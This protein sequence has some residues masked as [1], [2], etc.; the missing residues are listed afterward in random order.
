MPDI[1]H[2][3]DSPAG[4]RELI[5]STDPDDVHS[6]DYRLVNGRAGEALTIR[7]ANPANFHQAISDTGT[8]PRQDIWAKLFLPDGPPPFGVVIVVPGSL[9]LGPHHLTHAAAITDLGLAACGLDPFGPRS[10][11]STIA[12]QVQY[13]FAASAWDVLATAEALASRPDIDATRIGAQGHSRGGAAVLSAASVR[14]A[15][16]AGAPKLAGVYGAYPWCGHQFLDPD[17][18]G[19]RVRAIIGDQD[20]WCSPAQVQAHM[21]AIGVAGGDATVRIVPGAHHSF[22]RP[23]PL[24]LLGDAAVS[25][26]APT[27]YI[28]DDGAFI[29]PT[30]DQPDPSLVDLDG[31]RYALKAGYGTRG[32]HIGGT[33]ESAALFV[34]DMTD[35]W[36][37][38]LSPTPK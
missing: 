5:D 27:V 35:F 29:L 1:E 26:G 25:P 23:T 30:S 3:L 17:V 2:A 16:A 28:A 32:A 13:S 18:G 7:S 24:E 9:G 21:H 22:D 20:E 37:T 33:P 36:L 31:F 4:P 6:D 11:T 12:N 38:T 8:M 15:A 10:V 14:L 34:D 19:T